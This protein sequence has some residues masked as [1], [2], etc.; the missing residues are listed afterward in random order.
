MIKAI[1]AGTKPDTLL[2]LK[3]F[4]EADE[5]FTVVA[6]S[7]VPE[8]TMKLISKL[9][10]DVVALEYGT[11]DFDGVSIAGKIM[12]NTPVPIVLLGVSAD[13]LQKD[14]SISVLNAGAVTAV[15]LPDP[16]N[17]V[18]F[19]KSCETFKQTLALMSEIKVV[20]RIKR[21]S[22]TE[23]LPDASEEHSAKIKLIAIGASTGGPQII[24]TIL[25]RLTPGFSVPIVV[26]Q[27][28]TSGFIEG[29]TSWLNMTAKVHVQLASDGD[30]LK[31]GNC[32]IA[33]DNYHLEVINAGSI[34]LTGGEPVHSA[35]PS[36]SVLFKSIS[37]RCASHTVAIALTGMGKDG[38]AELGM[39][40]QNGGTTIAQD[41]ESSLIFGIPGEAIRLNAAQYIFNPDQI[42]SFLNNVHSTHVTGNTP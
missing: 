42:I 31:P 9:K 32:Y 2:S 36:I 12:G 11:A 41:M 17:P 7:S 23:F 6:T 16:E 28:I 8:D 19:Q 26:V 30:L 14:N 20:R 10:P 29:F 33:P 40:R 3:R 22:F 37:M 38:S 4:L 21:R 5:R 25:S 18:A 34:C 35:K 27:H 13:A 1:L 15:S 39:I 24:E